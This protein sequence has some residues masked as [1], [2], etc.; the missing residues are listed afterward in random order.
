MFSLNEMRALNLD[1]VLDNIVA[2]R[3]CRQ[4]LA[5]IMPECENGV[6]H[7]ICKCGNSGY[8]DWGRRSD[9]DKIYELA[10]MKDGELCCP[11]CHSKLIVV[12][13]STAGVGFKIGCTCGHCFDQI[14]QRKR[15]L[16]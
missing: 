4:T 3:N 5:Y 2:C 9:D 11:V 6:L 14:Y 10:D 13:E 1:V 12:C 7:L 15:K 8:I 16:Y